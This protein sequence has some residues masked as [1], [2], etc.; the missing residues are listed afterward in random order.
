MG[1]RA[2]GW[3]PGEDRRRERRL[4]RDVGGSDVDGLSENLTDLLVDGLRELAGVASPRWKYSGFPPIG[5][6]TGEFG[7]SLEVALRMLGGA[8]DLLRRGGGGTRQRRTKPSP[9]GGGKA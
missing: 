2:T 3:G 1:W 4:R 8:V 5:P 7:V 9:V 6:R